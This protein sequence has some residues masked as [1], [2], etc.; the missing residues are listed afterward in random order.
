MV[1]K[2]VLENFRHR[3]VRTIGSAFAIGI[4]V[5][6]I[7]TLVGVSRGMLSE[8]QQRARGV[9]ADIMIRD[10]GS[11][12]I[13]FSTNFK[14]KFIPIIRQE[15]H[16]VSVSGVLI[17][18]A[19]GIESV[20]G[21]DL[22]TFGEVSGGIQYLEGGP[23]QGPLDTIV[24]TVYSQ[25]KN[26]HP[27]STF[28]ILNKDW[29]VVGVV[30]SGKLAHMF[31]QIKVLQEL[32]ANDG[33]VTTAYVKLDNPANT[34]AVIEAMKV[35]FPTLKAYSM[36]DVVSYLT[37]DNVPMLRPFIYVIEALGILIGFV[38]VGLSMYMA[39]LERTRE[40]GILKALG[41]SPAYIMNML[42]RETLLL[43]IT[44]SIVGIILTYGTRSLIETFVPT[45]NQAIVP[46]F[47]PIATGIAIVGAM[48]GVVYPGMKA[49]RQD[50]IEALS[51]D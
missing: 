48:L 37:V 17:Q 28:R 31:V 33:Q 51:Y 45:M 3:P 50:A 8:M 7:L 23:F 10:G 12:L 29:R 11:S 5:T 19:Q 38:V 49:A 47:W 36:E 24:D 30:P 6:M 32:F 18:P 40:I 20:T 42:F 2:I 15:P 4:Q 44:G 21:I 39:V 14:E 26:L 34:A 1:N 9:G 35:K 25:T 27:G 41:A 46:D 22:K 43:A 13:G 16:V